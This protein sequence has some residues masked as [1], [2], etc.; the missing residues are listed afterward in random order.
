M[1]DL[2]NDLKAIKTQLSKDQKQDKKTEEKAQKEARL[3]KE[4]EE[5]AKIN[6]IKKLK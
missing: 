3:K 5:Y 6:E 4:F 1:N 2:F